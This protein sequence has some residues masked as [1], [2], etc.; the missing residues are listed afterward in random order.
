MM[1]CDG[2]LRA[3]VVVAAIVAAAPVAA[4]AQK[5]VIVVRHAERL[6]QSDDTPISDAGQKR[7][8]HL[9]EILRDAGVTVVYATEWQRTVQTAQPTADAVKAGITRYKSANVKEL[10]ATL[11]AKHASAVVL[12][13]GHSDTVPGIVA[14]Y[15]GPADIKIA[16]TEFD[17]L[18]VIT[19]RG[20]TAQVVR[21]HY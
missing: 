9:A 8:E 15:G 21:L 1:R 4:Y 2:W 20:K 3:G 10:V 19:P 6:D 12:V 17:N 16:P 11:R 7:A 14:A 13:V 5:A 18:F